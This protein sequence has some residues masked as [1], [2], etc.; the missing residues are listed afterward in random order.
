MCAGAL[1]RPVALYPS[2][3]RQGSFWDRYPYFL[4]N[5][6][7]ALVGLLALLLAFWYLP[8]TVVLKQ[9]EQERGGDGAEGQ[10]GVE[11][12]NVTSSASSNN[13]SKDT[14]SEDMDV[15]APKK[16]KQSSTSFKELLAFPN[17][18]PYVAGYFVMSLVAVVYDEVVPLWCLSS[19]DRGGLEY[20]SKEVRGEQRGWMES[21]GECVCH[22][23][24]MNSVPL[25][26][27]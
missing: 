16:T 9:E 14:S 4:P 2:V 10:K 20:T 15:D 7:T 5:A 17:V 12:T 21:E 27:F 26:L 24:L 22:F 1:A 8:E 11:L 3:F 6:F 13:N 19:I 25:C 18:V 23:V